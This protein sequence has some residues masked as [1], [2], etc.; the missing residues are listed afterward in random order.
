MHTH[1]SEVLV[2][3]VEQCKSEGY[4]CVFAHTN[5]A[6]QLPDAVLDLARL[7]E[8][9]QDR[10]FVRLLRR[11]IALYLIRCFDFPKL[12]SSKVFVFIV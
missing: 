10:A 5:I 12:H 4:E 11:V 9:V 6:P 3:W 2:K 1:C 8:L 7:V